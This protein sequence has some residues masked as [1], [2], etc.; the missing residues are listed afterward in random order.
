MALTQYTELQH[1]SAD[2]DAAELDVTCHTT[3]AF[4]VSLI[5]HDCGLTAPPIRTVKE[6][7]AANGE[8]FFI[9]SLNEGTYLGMD[10]NDP[11]HTGVGFYAAL[12]RPVF[13]D[14]VLKLQQA[15]FLGAPA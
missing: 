14:H 9:F 15:E 8:G 12:E 4:L 5:D 2:M 10:G 1:Q 11:V 6:V 13:E 3:E 7:L